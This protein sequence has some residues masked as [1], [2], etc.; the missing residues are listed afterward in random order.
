MHSCNGIDF[1]TG[2]YLN[3]PATLAGLTS[4][5]RGETVDADQLTQFQKHLECCAGGEVEALK[6]RID[7]LRLSKA[8]WGVIF[9][10]DE[11]PE[12]EK[13]LLPLLERRKQQAG[14]LYKEFKGP[15]GYKP[16]QT[17]GQFLRDADGYGPVDPSKGVPYYLLIVGSPEKIPYHFQYLVDVQYA[18]GR[19]HFDDVADYGR[20]ANSVVAA[21][22]SELTLPR[23]AAFFGVANPNDTVTQGS[24]TGLIRP[25]ADFMA[26]LNDGWTVA[27]P[28]PEETTRAHLRALIEDAPALVM[29][30]SHGLGMSLE[31]PRQQELTGALLC[32]DWPG[33]GSG[34][35][36]PEALFT[37]ADVP[38]SAR[39]HGSIFFLFACY[40]AGMPKFEDF[41]GAGGRK[42]VAA[43]A[44]VSSL[45]KRLLAHPGGGALAVIGHIERAWPTSF[46]GP[47]SR[48]QLQTFQ[49]TWLRLMD[50]C[51][52]GYA[53]EFFNMRF[54]EL[55]TMLAA[56]L[57]NDGSVKD[58]SPESIE[59][60]NLWTANNDA[61]N[62][63]V[64]GDPAIRLRVEPKQ[65]AE[66]AIAN[67]AEEAGTEALP[68]SY[69]FLS[70]NIEGKAEPESV[71]STTLRRLIE[72]LEKAV[73]GLTAVEVAT[74]TSE[75]LSHV[76][77]KDGAFS[78]AALRARTRM[79]LDGKT[80]N[81]VPE[82][83]GKIDE[84]LW[85]VHMDSVDKAIANR[86][87]MLKVAS[88]VASSLFAIVKK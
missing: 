73:D 49:S 77:Y 31:N 45:P 16:G 68:G 37:A 22:Q 64:I 29:T 35:V 85:R 27:C 7:P 5:A 74:Y 76:E 4:A 20:Y 48:E 6:E 36:R 14:P 32:Q 18:V 42:Q 28:P 53:M 78:G 61:R 33:R 38:D 40:G 3:G 63:C 10:R 57:R 75:D 9:A 26:G 88:S 13:A 80:V 52:I 55:S 24:A 15:T 54:A 82:R 65:E 59:L 1:S 70:L 47:R 72:L 34:P 8:G 21:E 41:A 23:R 25:M 84:A 67:A 71:L 39:L 50:G 51:P 17:K 81:L 60:V 30:A 43:E 62:Y 12:I 58:K 83:D 2:D 19:I 11:D 66:M 46:E 87:E 79:S 86:S 56:E 44:F 69:E